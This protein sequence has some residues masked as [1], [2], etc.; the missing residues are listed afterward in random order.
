MSNQTQV[1]E[2]QPQAVDPVQKRIE[3]YNHEKLNRLLGY[4]ANCSKIAE[5]VA[6]N[7]ARL[8]G[9]AWDHCHIYCAIEI[10]AGLTYGGFEQDA[11]AI[12]RRWPGR[13][14][15]RVK[16]PSTCGVIDY[17]SSPEGEIPIRIKNAETVKWVLDT[18]AVEIEP[19][20]ESIGAREEAA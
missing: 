3:E 13:I 19:E 11:R 20:K 4:A 6:A 8:D 2:N 17:L 18:S 16:N 10:L 9:T 15:N 14:W 12:A 5:F 7:G 1:I